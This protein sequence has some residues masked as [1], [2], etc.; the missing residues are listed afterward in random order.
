MSKKTLLAILGIALVLGIGLTYRL[1]MMGTETNSSGTASIG[2][3]FTLVNQDGETVTQDDFKGKYMLTYFGYTFCPD[4]C[5]TELQ[6]M[7][8]A[9]DMMPQDIADEITPVFFTVDPERDTVEAV[10]EYVPYFHD[11][12]VGLTGTV[13]QTTAAA[14]AFRVYYAKAIPEGEPEDTDT[15]LMDHSSF[16]YLMDREGKFVRHFN[17]GTSPEDMAKGVT[18]AVKNNG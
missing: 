3:P 7:G 10:A 9:L 13:E 1:M 8:T 16:V 17:Y 11:R 14:K 15:Y 4:V 5:P 12:M 2:G 18:E 6:V